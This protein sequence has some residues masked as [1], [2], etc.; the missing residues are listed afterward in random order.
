MKQDNLPARRVKADLDLFREA[1]SNPAIRSLKAGL[2]CDMCVNRVSMALKSQPPDKW[3]GAEANK[4][5]GAARILRDL[6][7]ELA[8]SGRGTESKIR[9]IT[10]EMG[11]ILGGNKGKRKRG[12]SQPPQGQGVTGQ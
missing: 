4:W 7:V 2:L 1:D 5:A 9:D 11:R 3:T 12:K 8:P 10:A 6:E